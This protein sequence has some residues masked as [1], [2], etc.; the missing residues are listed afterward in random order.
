M[1]SLAASASILLLSFGL[2]SDRPAQ[3]DAE[4][5]VT[6]AASEY[7]VYLV[8]NVEDERKAP[9]P[10]SLRS[11]VLQ[12]SSS[13]G[14]IRVST[15]DRP[16]QLEAPLHLGNNTIVEGACTRPPRIFGPKRGSI[17]YIDGS[18]DVTIRRLALSFKGQDAHR[19]TGDCV[20]VRGG[21]DRVLITDSQL[22]QCRDGMIDVTQVEG[23][24]PTRITIERNRFTDHDKGFLISAPA[25]ARCGKDG[26]FAITAV[27]SDNEM[28]RIGQ[29]MPRASG[30]VFVHLVGNDISVTPHMRSDG[31]TGGAY[32]AYADKGASIFAEKNILRNNSGRK[33]RGFWAELAASRS[34][35]AQRGAIRSSSNYF[36][37]HFVHQFGPAERVKRLRNP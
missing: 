17:F 34:K 20:T 28:T 3:V 30:D 13:G 1:Q 7:P 8:T 6:P 10:S 31:A 23:D 2:W 11:A 36:E 12:A 35:C 27:I 5:E 25:D 37:G 19:S 22:S 14:T 33:L 4:A 32:V 9:P 15:C 29:R 18:R 26:K 16:I 21:A 24:G